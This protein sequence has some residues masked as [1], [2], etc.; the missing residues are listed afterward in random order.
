MYYA[1]VS[2]AMVCIVL[3]KRGIGLWILLQ[4]FDEVHRRFYVVSHKRDGSKEGHYTCG[5]ATYKS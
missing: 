2:S 4:I 1:L 5:I 3:L